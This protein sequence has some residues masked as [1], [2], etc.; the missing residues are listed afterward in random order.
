MSH[1]PERPTRYV[2]AACQVVHAG[3]PHHISGAEHSFEPPET[4]GCCEESEFVELG[5]WT[6]HHE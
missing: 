6:R 4:C 3:T 5:D 2:C 1:V